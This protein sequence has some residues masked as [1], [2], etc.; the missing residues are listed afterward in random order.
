MLKGTFERGWS[1]KLKNHYRLEDDW[2]LIM[3]GS[4]IYEALYQMKDIEF[5]DG[6]GIPYLMR[7]GQNKS[8]ETGLDL[9]RGICRRFANT[10]RSET[11]ELK[12]SKVM[13]MFSDFIDL[14]KVP[15]DIVWDID[16]AYSMLYEDPDRKSYQDAWLHFGSKAMLPDDAPRVTK[17]TTITKL[18]GGSVEGR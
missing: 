10:N 4:G 9:F 16:R 12:S 8:F 2:K 13:R 18:L 14:G 6:R 11:W 15:A 1:I 7:N 17:N 5:H 3:N